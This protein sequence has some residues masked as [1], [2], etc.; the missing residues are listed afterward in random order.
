MRGALC[1]FRLPY[2][3][4]IKAFIQSRY[5]IMIFKIVYTV[6]PLLFSQILA[7]LFSRNI[8]SKLE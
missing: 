5:I 4:R 6:K 1:I 2:G 7:V 8:L 3:T